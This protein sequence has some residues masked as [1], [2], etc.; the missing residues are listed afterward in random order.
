MVSMTPLSLSEERA[1]AVLLV[2]A[3]EETDRGGELLSHEARRA[4]TRA[5]R[6]GQAAS[7]AHGDRWISHRAMA[8]TAELDKSITFLPR[9][10]RWTRPGRGLLLP[11]ALVAFVLG[12]FTQAL[13]G[14]EGRV[15]H[16]LAVPLL[17]LVAW[18]VVVLAFTV[19]RHWLPL[20]S[21]ARPLTD[22]LLAFW[23]RRLRK[24]VERLPRVGGPQE[25]EQRELLSRALGKY[26]E[27][28]LPAVAPLAAA[29]LRRLLHAGAGLLVAGVVAGMYFRALGWEYRVTWESTFLGAQAAQTLLETI[30]APAS[31]LLDL[32][33][34]DVAA[35]RSPEVGPAGTLDS[36]LR[37]HRCPLRAV[38]AF[39]LL[40]IGEP[41]LRRGA[42]P[43]TT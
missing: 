24:R 27:F 13:E 26:L 16:V 34:P 29:R 15:I 9:L 4:A 43:A 30:F 18:N 19:V 37:H 3:V 11:V 25:E 23:Q 41:A 1:Q 40:H 36:P 28:W 2:R 14:G 22:G 10:L 6:E 21:L 5:A 31:T 17:A 38:A 39:R 32:P 8:L 20:G 35:L 42:L 12:L 7:K 33:V